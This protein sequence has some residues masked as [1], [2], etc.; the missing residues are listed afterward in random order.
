MTFTVFFFTIYLFWQCFLL[1][2]FE[3]S[4]AD[5]VGEAT[6]N[7]EKVG[8]AERK[9]V[10]ADAEK[11]AILY[12]PEL[13]MKVET[14][15]YVQWRIILCTPAE[16]GAIEILV[17]YNFMCEA[18]LLPKITLPVHQAFKVY[19]FIGSFDEDKGEKKDDKTKEDDEIVY[20]TKNGTVYHNSK[21]CTYLHMSIS[22][23][24]EN[25]V[26]KERNENGGK[27]YPCSDCAECDHTG[28]VY[29]TEYGD[30]FHYNVNCSN[31]Y[32]DI[33]EIKKSEAGNRKPCSKCGN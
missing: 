15:D 6:K 18:P 13:L 4:V 22:A 14:P 3:L 33:Q 10:G 7:M 25:E 30:R 21:N 32:R 5:G 28:L 8:Y 29:I 1:I 27:Y 31:I 26:S 11:L 20:I 19:P 23:V 9:L 2:F 24:N 12:L 17:R 16:D